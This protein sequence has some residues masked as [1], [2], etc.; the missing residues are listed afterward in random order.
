MVESFPWWTEENKK[1]AKDLET[2]VLNHYEEAERH[3]FMKKFPHGI[4]NELKELG[5]FGAGVP[6][7][8]GGMELGA[9]G[10]CIVA[11]Q[12]GRLYCVG[13]CFTVSMLGGLHQLIEFGTEEQKEYWLTKI[14]KGQL[15][16]VCITEPFAGS[17]AANVYTSAVKD[18]D[19]WVINGKKRYITNAGTGHRYFMYIKTSD[20]PKDRAAYRHLS[21]FVFERG[22][23]GFSLEKIN[24]LIGFDNVPNGYLNMKD[25]H[26]PESAMVGEQGQG[27]EIMMSGLNFERMIGS[28]G[29]GGS[30]LDAA[31]L[32]HF[33]SQRRI[34]FGK[35]LKFI[36]NVSFTLARL[37]ARLKYA[38]LMSFYTAYLLDLGK[39]P[40]IESSIAKWFNVDWAMQ[41]GIETVQAMGGD[42]LTRFYPVE[43]MIREAKIGQ[44]VA[45]TNE[46]MAYLVYRVATSMA[47]TKELETPF[48][49]KMDEEAGYPI[50]TLDKGPYVEQEA[51]S[52]LVLKILAE[53]YRV[54]P[55]LYM[56]IDDI[57]KQCKGSR[58]KI[59]EICKELENN[60]LVVAFY[61]RKGEIKMVKANYKG[62]D[63][64]YPP[65]HYRWFPDWYD[66][67]RDAFFG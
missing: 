59:R 67:E 11:E 22:T 25:V 28:A 6:K 41:S 1:L 21:T 10:A 51:T 38:R 56:M 66:I 13:H 39:Q 2:F 58:K 26:L 4:L 46:V 35:P 5:Y 47:M 7:K 65:E 17:D 27:W 36:E 62:L 45:G 43:R 63:K 19:E 42:A 32:L 16:A 64:A 52:E 12:L 8:Y 24:D 29:V 61:D 30:L 40:I 23:K 53:D 50:A 60:G 48:R 34:Q 20:D 44:L 3:Y 57:K 33:H 31:R 9:T 54:N 15:G 18:G 14:A 37:V 49:F 55:S